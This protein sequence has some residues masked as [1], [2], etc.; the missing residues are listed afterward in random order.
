M[1]LFPLFFKLTKER[2]FLNLIKLATSVGTATNYLLSFWMFIFEFFYVS[3]VVYRI[4]CCL[5][6]FTCM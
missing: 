1:P 5:Y 6:Q 4:F 2:C 3:I